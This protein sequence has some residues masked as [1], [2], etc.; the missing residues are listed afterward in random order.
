MELTKWTL[1]LPEKRLT[2]DLPRDGHNSVSGTRWYKSVTYRYVRNGYYT[3]T[4]LIL[5]P[6]NGGTILKDSYIGTILVAVNIALV[7]TFLGPRES[8]RLRGKWTQELCSHQS[9]SFQC[10]S[11]SKLYHRVDMSGPKNK[12]RPWETLWDSKISNCNQKSEQKRPM[13]HLK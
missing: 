7:S 9:I 12:D 1:N 6:W 8:Y 13:R 3:K 4:A 5:K 11:L 10:K 2:R